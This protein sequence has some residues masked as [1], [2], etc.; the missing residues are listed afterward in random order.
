[1]NGTQAAIAAGYKESGAAARASILLT[2]GVIRKEIDRIRDEK[3]I[4]AQAIAEKFDITKE[5][6]ITKQVEVLNLAIDG[7]Q[8]NAANRSLENLHKFCG[9]DIA[10]PQAQE[11][12]IDELLNLVDGKTRGLPPTIEHEDT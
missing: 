11:N 10:T 5:W 6:L 3:L 8:T 9:F 7:G 12:L 1:M 4:E 2:K